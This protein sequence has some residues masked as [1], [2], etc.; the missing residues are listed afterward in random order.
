MQEAMTVKL[1]DW[2]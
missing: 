2:L 1:A